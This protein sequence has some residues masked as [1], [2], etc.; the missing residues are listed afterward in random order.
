MTAFVSN[1]NAT[2]Q[3][4]E[5]LHP[6]L[7]LYKVDLKSF[8]DRHY[9][10]LGGRLEPI[11]ETIRS[12]HQ[13]GIWLEIVTLL[14]PGFN[15]NDDEFRGLTRSGQRFARHPV[16]RYRVSP[17]LQN[18]F[19]RRHSSQRFAARGSHWPGRRTALR[20]EATSG[21]SGIRRHS[22]PWLR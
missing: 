17:G 7:D 8:D 6:F 5:Y 9:R 11:L 10:E 4:L 18:D 12:L 22:L 2:P 16:A 14:I 13:M 1:G 21:T 15:D 20:Y 19:A 3:A